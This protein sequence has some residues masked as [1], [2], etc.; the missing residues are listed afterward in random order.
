MKLIDTHTHLYLDNF[1]ADRN[2]IIKN[3]ISHGVETMLLPA[4]DSTSFDAMMELS[5]LHPQNC[6]PM[7]GLHPTS[8]KDNYEN[9]MELVEK[10]LSKGSYIA[11]GE[12]GIDLYWDKSHFDQQK[13][14][15]K[16]QLRLALKYKLPVAIHTR[17]SFDEIYP[18]VKEESTD[19]LT[20]VFHCFG[21]TESEA[22]KIIDLGFMMGIGGIITFKNS[23]LAEVV[24][25]IPNIH[26]ILETDAPFL[27]PAPY[28][29][30]RN[31]SAYLTYIASKLAEVK[32]IDVE[33]IAEITTKNAIVLF[34][35]V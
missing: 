26:L 25:K 35:L 23:G 15:F 29:G 1:D 18:I 19:E 32:K 20:G 6:F 10:E 2:Q 31:Q 13:D 34:K 27:T 5:N 8:V 9:E 22:Q 3:A 7:I 24:Q 17:D 21:G 11:V 16:R 28:R 14:A 4:I 12:I 33:E 30:K